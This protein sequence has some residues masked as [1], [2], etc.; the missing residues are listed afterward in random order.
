MR[1]LLSGVLLLFAVHA[2]AGTAA[3]Y[4]WESRID[5]RLVCAQTSPGA[6]WKQFAGPFLDANCSKP[7]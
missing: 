1:S 6:Q 2:A 3:W 4:R 5:G 7:R